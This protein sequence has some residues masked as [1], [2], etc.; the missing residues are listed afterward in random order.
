SIPVNLLVLPFASVILI[1]GA[2]ACIL[3]TM[4]G[5]GHLF[6]PAR[7]VINAVRQICTG[8]CRLPGAVYVTGAPGAFRIMLFAAGIIYG[9][10]LLKAGRKRAGVLMYVLV[11][12]GLIRPA[13]KDTGIIFPDVGQGDC[14]I[15]SSPEACIIVDGGSSTVDSVGRYRIEPLLKYMG[16]DTIDAVIMTHMDSDHVNGLRELMEGSGE[17]PLRTRKVFFS[18][19][20]V[21]EDKRE[22]LMKLAA[23]KGIETGVLGRG[24][25]IKTDKVR[26][27]CLYP[28]EYETSED[29]NGCSLVFYVKAEGVSALLTGDVD[30]SVEKLMAGDRRISDVDI[31]K[32]SHHGSRFGTCRELLDEAKPEAAVISCARYNRYGHP[33]R[34]VVKRLTQ[35]GAWVLRTYWKGCIT[36]ICRED[37]YDVETYIK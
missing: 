32:V 36:F 6:I 22:E 1:T 14:I 11:I 37:G 2:A 24:S 25:I 28:S 30:D 5:A 13:L 8:A 35:C 21:N 7:A 31:L 10:G 3:G 9:T 33:D 19:H 29:E 18:C 17:G 26:L 4:F 15:I 27:E 23:E 20:T 16:I 12:L 34:N